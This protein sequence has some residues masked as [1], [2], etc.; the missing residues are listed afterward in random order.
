VVFVA[1]AAASCSSALTKEE[2]DRFEGFG[3]RAGD[4]AEFVHAESFLAA[5]QARQCL[6]LCTGLRDRHPD[7]ILIHRLYQDARLALGDAARVKA[8]YEELA[9]RSPSA[10]HEILASRV[11]TNPEAGALR[12]RNAYE[13]DDRNPWAWYAYAWWSARLPSEKQ[14]AE[15]ALRRALDLNPSF[16]PALRAYAVLLRDSDPTSAAEAIESYVRKFPTREDRVLLA[17]LRLALGGDE[18]E[19]AEREFRQLLEERPDDS[20]CAKGLAAALLELN[21]TDEAKA[22]YKSLARSNP[23]DPSPEFNLAVVAENEGKLA[24][25]RVHYQKF[26]DKGGDQPFL[27][28][29]RA[30]LSIQEIEEKIL[31]ASGPASRP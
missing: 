21:R 23:N 30:R 29:S 12:A 31:P 19:E 20:V 9:K 26:L 27:L 2:I 17:S 16:Y 7:N 18:V 14:R 11:Q 15:A 10:I 8:E 24:E 5:G 3:G 4:E 6:D 25:A 28:Q 22:L 13:M 1:L